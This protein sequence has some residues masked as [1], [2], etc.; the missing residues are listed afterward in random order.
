MRLRGRARTLRLVTLAAAL[1]AVT[2]LMLPA[3]AG[4]DGTNT[5]NFSIFPTAPGGTSELTIGCFLSTATGGGGTK[6][7]VEDHPAAVWHTGAARQVTVTTGTALG[8]TVVTST[9]GH[10]SAADLNN[11]ISGTGIP[12]DTFIKAVGTNTVTLSKAANA[13]IAIGAKLLVDSYDGRTVAD[14][15]GR[16]HV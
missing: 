7:K 12:V 16:A 5:C 9:S 15:I 2:G 13:A 3:P 10:F 11:P 8:G 14:E 1:T 6:Y 4:A